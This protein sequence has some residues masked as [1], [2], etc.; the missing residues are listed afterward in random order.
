MVWLP[1]GEKSLRMCLL[2][3]TQYTNMTDRQTDRRTDRHRHPTTASTALMRS[4]A[5]QKLQ[6][7]VLTDVATG[8]TI[9]DF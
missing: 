3:S 2:V 6:A 1:D 5:R 8:N 7:V 9:R 4:I